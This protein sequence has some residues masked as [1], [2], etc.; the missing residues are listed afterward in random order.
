MSLPDNGE[1]YN[2]REVTKHVTTAQIGERKDR[3]RINSLISPLQEVK[4]EGAYGS[5]SGHEGAAVFVTW[6]CYQ[7]IA[8]PGNKTAALSWPD[9]YTN[10]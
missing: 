1:I 2:W 10:P 3:Q 5:D 4:H 7:L 8:K 9:P 6:F